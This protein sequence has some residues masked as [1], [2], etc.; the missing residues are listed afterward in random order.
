MS[1]TSIFLQPISTFDFCIYMSW[2][3]WFDWIKF[4]VWINSLDY[5][6]SVPILLELQGSAHK[7]LNQVFT[8]IK[9]QY[10]R[11]APQTFFE[12]V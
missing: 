10:P 8:V 11:T 5:A 6:A 4:N 9:V 7:K 3:I 2:Y 12:G 1:F